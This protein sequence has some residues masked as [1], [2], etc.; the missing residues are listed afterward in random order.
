MLYVAIVFIRPMEWMP[1]LRGFEILTLGLLDFVAV[2]T[3]LATIAVVARKQWNIKS[4]PQNLLMLGFFFAILMSQVSRGYLGEIGHHG[5]LIGAFATFGKIVLLYFFIAINVNTLQRMKILIRVMIVGCLFMTL[6]GI[7]QWHTGVGFGGQG[8]LYIRFRDEYRVIAFGFFND[9]NDL[10]L[11]LV[12]ILPF[13]ISPIHKEGANGL[14]RVGCVVFAGAIG[15]CIFRTNSRG[16]W[17]AL[18]TMMLAYF[19]AH[20]AKKRAVV[21]GIIAIVAFLMVAPSRLAETSAREASAR[22]RLTSWRHGNMM[23]KQWPV[24]GAGYGR[25]MEYDEEGKVAHNSFVHCYAELGLFGYFFWLALLIASAWDAYVLG[26]ADPQ[27][28]PEKAEIS[29]LA[30]TSQASLVGYMAAAFFLSRTYT[31]PLYIFFGFFAAMRTVYEQDS[32]SSVMTF[33]A[34]HLKYAF[35]AVPL[36]ILGLYILLRFM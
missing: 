35:A 17:L 36:S 22:G 34:R 13:L 12:A 27:E 19:M 25:Y 9:P 32:D 10:A 14:V 30:K 4:A 18:V 7:L 20:F 24:F 28:K 31:L 26:K 5:G 1:G 33:K 23:L 2:A 3:T 11:M 29:R 8:P 21:F 16:G 15:Y 6:H